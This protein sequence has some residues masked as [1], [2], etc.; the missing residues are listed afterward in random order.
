VIVI[1][2]NAILC[3]YIVQPAVFA[4]SVTEHLFDFLATQ[5]G[6]ITY[7][8]FLYQLWRRITNSNCADKTPNLGALFRGPKL[9]SP[10]SQ[11]AEFL[12]RRKRI[13]HVSLRIFQLL[14]I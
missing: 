8:N 7:D 13:S 6:T 14:L 9:S 2:R 11:N 5:H 1:F 4:A 3:K 10:I 12:S